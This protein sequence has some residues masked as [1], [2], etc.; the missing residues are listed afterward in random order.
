MIIKIDGTTLKNFKHP[1]PLLNDG[2]KDS[3]RNARYGLIRNRIARVPQ[4]NLV[5]APQSKADMEDLLALLSP[6][7]FEVEYYSPHTKQTETGIFYAGPHTP[8]VLK[9]S[10]E[11]YD[12]MEVSLIAYDGL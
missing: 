11:W 4:I 3:R 8:K 7:S 9:K 12:E 10:P 5:F 2:D 1:E 6:A